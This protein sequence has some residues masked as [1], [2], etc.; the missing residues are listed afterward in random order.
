MQCFANI[1]PCEALFTWEARFP[2]SY[3]TLFVDG[4][5]HKAKRKALN[6]VEVAYVEVVLGGGQQKTVT[7]AIT[8]K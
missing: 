8:S 4:V 3:S 5:P 1:L 6:G 2:G 7:A